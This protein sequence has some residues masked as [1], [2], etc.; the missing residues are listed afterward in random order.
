[1]FLFILLGLALVGGLVGWSVGELRRR[2]RWLTAFALGLPFWLYLPAAIPLLI[3]GGVEALGW[4][5]MGLGMLGF[6]MAAWI[7]PSG[8][9]YAVS[10]FGTEARPTA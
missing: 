1:M 7:I 5:L 2:C 10:R 8:I 9:G 6:P 3:S 4:W